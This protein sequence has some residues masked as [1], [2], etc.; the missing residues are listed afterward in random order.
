V[1]IGGAL[2]MAGSVRVFIVATRN[3]HKLRELRAVAIG[4]L[5]LSPC[6]SNCPIVDET[7]NTYEENARLKAI[8]VS[9]F[10]GSSAIGDDTGIEVDALKGEP[11][12]RSA[13]YAGPA[14]L[15][16]DNCRKVLK[17]LKGLSRHDRT[18]RYHTVLVA[19]LTD[20]YE[21]VSHGTCEGHIASVPHG[22]KE[23][24]YQSIFIPA[25]GDG[26]TFAEMEL[27]E[28]IKISHHSRAMRALIQKLGV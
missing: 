25:E 13:R 7:G 23:F 4:A 14:E 3:P 18:A 28:R 6:P 10:T 17:A 2:L 20:G 21:L 8:E 12:I 11:G 26:R 1:P 19:R 27:S 9:R 22:S 5:A 15:S 16:I 24:G